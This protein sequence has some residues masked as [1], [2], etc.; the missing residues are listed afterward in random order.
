MLDRTPQF[1]LIGQHS[2]SFRGAVAALWEIEPPIRSLTLSRSRAWPREPGPV[3]AYFSSLLFHFSLGF[4]LTSVPLSLLLER[5]PRPPTGSDDTPAPVV[6]D[7]TKLDLAD[8]LPPQRPPGPGGTPGSGSSAGPV[9]GGTTAQDPR[10]EII[11]NPREPDNVRQT[12]VQPDSIADRKIPTD[13]RLPNLTVADV[14]PATQAPPK[15]APPP[16]ES[17]PAL[18]EQLAPLPPA[19]PTAPAVTLPTVAA[20]VPVANIETPASLPP[21]ATPPAPPPKA[22]SASNTPKPALPAPAPSSAPPQTPARATTAASAG[23][24][25]PPATPA[26]SDSSGVTSGANRLISLS[27]E[28]APKRDWITLPPG[29]RQGA[30]SVTP[31][32]IRPGSPGGL[33]VGEDGAGKGAPG[34]GGDASVAAGKEMSGGGGTGV[35]DARSIPSVNTDATATNAFAGGSLPPLPPE[36]LIYPVNIAALR[37]HRSGLVV[38]AGPGGGG[39]LPAYGVL[40]G[41]RIYTIYLPMPGRNWILQFCAAGDDPPPVQASQI[42]IHMEAPLVPPTAIDQFDF[43]RPP[44]PEENAGRMIV[45]HGVIRPDGSVGNLEVLQ[46][47]EPSSDQAAVAAFARWKFAPAM[48]AANPV[49]VEVLVGIP[50][51]VSSA[52]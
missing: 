47:V 15:P 34:S 49:A 51:T 35:A 1:E 38:S 42:E 11:S 48:R 21:A 14:A 44:L 32:D 50:A 13:V 20:P 37:L 24:T 3:P 46:R 10:V 29:N 17:K 25:V 8:Y 7:L 22:A 40:H 41:H 23:S 27:I 52:Q 31:L 43:H 28:P 19:A 26:G 30:F 39:G 5:A 33:Q 18:P 4:F 2:D 9:V 45:L 36:R 12:I 6:Y 16:P